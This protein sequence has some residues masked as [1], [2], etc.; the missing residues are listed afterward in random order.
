MRISESSTRERYPSKSAGYRSNSRPFDSPPSALPHAVR[1]PKSRIKS[2]PGCCGLS[3]FPACPASS[4]SH[5]IDRRHAPTGRR[6]F[7]RSGKSRLPSHCCRQPGICRPPRC[8]VRHP[9]TGRHRPSWSTHLL[10]SHLFGFDVVD[11][12]ARPIWF[13]SLFRFSHPPRLSHLPAQHSCGPYRR[14]I[15]DSCSLLGWRVQ[16]DRMACLLLKYLSHPEP[17]AQR[18]HSRRPVVSSV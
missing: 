15:Q 14:R 6:S 17:H 7:T 4:I 2:R 16:L 11:G 8:I 13:P 5:A 1:P 18:I 10:R 12:A 3:S 9:G